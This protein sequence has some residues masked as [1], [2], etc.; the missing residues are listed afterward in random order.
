VTN[1]ILRHFVEPSH[2]QMW[3]KC[4]KYYPVVQLLQTNAYFNFFGKKE[5]NE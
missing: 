1:F 2:K 4:S 3:T 5:L